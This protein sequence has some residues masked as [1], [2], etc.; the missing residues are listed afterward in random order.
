MLGR[1]DYLDVF[2]QGIA[3]SFTDDQLVKLRDAC[4]R[5]DP[6]LIQGSATKYIRFEDDPGAVEVC[7][8]AISYPFVLNTESPTYSATRATRNCAEDKFLAV[9]D[10]CERRLAGKYDPTSIHRSWLIFTNMFDT[11]NRDHILPELSGR[12][13]QILLKRKAVA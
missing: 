5:D 8:C 4:D 9:T 7:G 12:C 3:P 6:H 10:E 2:E 11:A 13:S 1:D